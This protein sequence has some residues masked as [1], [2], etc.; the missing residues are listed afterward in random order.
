VPGGLGYNP[1]QYLAGGPVQQQQPQLQP[2]PQQQQYH[3]QPQ[4]YGPGDQSVFH[5]L[6]AMG[7]PNM[8]QVMGGHFGGGLWGQQ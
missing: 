6:G 7:F 3:I 4:M 1:Y 8:A 2:Q 5:Q